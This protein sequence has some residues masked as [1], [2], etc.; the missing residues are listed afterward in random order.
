MKLAILTLWS[1]VFVT[2][3]LAPPSAANTSE[4]LEVQVFDLAPLLDPAR[5]DP[6]DPLGFFPLDAR[7]FFPWGRDRARQDSYQ[8]SDESVEALDH[9]AISGVLDESLAAAGLS[10]AWGDTA[11]SF[12]GGLLIVRGGRPVL[13]RVRETLAWLEESATLR[14][15]VRVAFLEAA[16]G[17][18]AGVLRPSECQR[19]LGRA[20]V[21]ET[22]EGLVAAGRRF[23]LGS[24]E[25]NVYLHDYD[26]EVAQDAHVADPR[27][28][29]LRSGRQVDG[30]LELL[31]SGGVALSISVDRVEPELPFRRAA[32]RATAVGDVELPSTHALRAAM[33][34]VVP[35]GG[36]ILISVEDGS[37]ATHVLVTV[38]PV[39]QVRR[40]LGEEQPVALFPVGFLTSRKTPF[41]ASGGGLLDTFRNTGT[42]R[43]EEG[44]GFDDEEESVTDRFLEAGELE[45]IV[46]ELSEST[47]ESTFT[48]EDALGLWGRPEIVEQVAELL[49]F[50]ER[51]RARNVSIDASVYVVGPDAGLGSDP[52]IETLDRDGERVAR[53]SVTTL[54]GTGAAMFA[55]HEW[56]SI[57]DYDVEIAQAATIADPVVGHYTA[58][59]S[60]DARPLVHQSGDRVSVRLEGEVAQLDWRG[61]M[62]D[63]GAKDIGALDLPSR[64]SLPVSAQVTLGADEHRAILLG[65]GVDGERY[66]LVV[67]AGFPNRAR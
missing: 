17:I 28:A 26:V 23:S 49:A 27:L 7:G 48:L 25:E 65:S 50:L 31:R 33:H 18:R 55:G 9:D 40:V 36:G 43:I 63:Y 57:A 12:T 47:L 1:A 44:F 56:A 62:Q 64:H 6:G 16:G 59:F 35:D 8:R 14:V 34:V 30:R 38:G 10:D 53:A 42:L 46:R 60:L 32:T 4:D 13:D 29:V 3:P 58:G 21:L 54:S 15:P 41:Q 5:A 20:S 19:V 61:E 11:H 67:R 24:V 52:S 45:D 2:L 39:P 22:F 51:L 66:V 37:D